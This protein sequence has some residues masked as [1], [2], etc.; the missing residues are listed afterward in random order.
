MAAVIVK[1][2]N[3]ISI[4]GVEAAVDIAHNTIFGH[5]RAVWIRRISLVGGSANDK[6]EVQYNA[7]TGATICR[8]LCP[9]AGE[10]KDCYF[11]DDRGLPMKIYIDASDSTL[12]ANHKVLIEMA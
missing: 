3:F 12:S 10:Q 11:G 9:T 4:T 8:P 7:D 1:D 6:L 5:D 2:E